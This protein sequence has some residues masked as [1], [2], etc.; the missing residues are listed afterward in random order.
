MDNNLYG[1]TSETN[2]HFLAIYLCIFF[3]TCIARTTCFA[4]AWRNR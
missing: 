2:L 3:N 4:T 1:E